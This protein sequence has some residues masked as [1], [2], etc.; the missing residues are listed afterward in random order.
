MAEGNVFQNVV[1]PLLENKGKL[2]SAPSTSAKTACKPYL[3]HNYIINAFGTSGAF[4]GTDTF[5]SPNSR[6][7]PSLALRRHPAMSL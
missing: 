2:F 4:A 3:A 1:S 5:S 6:D 7:T